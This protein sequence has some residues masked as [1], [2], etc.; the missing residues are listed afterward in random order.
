MR[1]RRGKD[2]EG[3]L[4]IA[5]VRGA[6]CTYDEEKC[7]ENVFSSSFSSLMTGSLHL[8]TIQRCGMYILQIRCLVRRTCLINCG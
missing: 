4:A 5:K 2:N 1:G 7:I 6:K 8:P 3:T